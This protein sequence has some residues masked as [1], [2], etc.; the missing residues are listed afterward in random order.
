MGILPPPSSHPAESQPAEHPS[1]LVG[2]GFGV[3][4]A[5]LATVIFTAVLK[6]QNSDASADVKIMPQLPLT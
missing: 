5:I 4:F 2:V 1:V 6:P 3:V